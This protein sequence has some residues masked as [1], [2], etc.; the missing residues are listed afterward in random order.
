MVCPGGHD[1]DSEELFSL[2]TDVLYHFR[3]KEEES[4]V[5]KRHKF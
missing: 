5:Q 4:A 2:C 1:E 3:E